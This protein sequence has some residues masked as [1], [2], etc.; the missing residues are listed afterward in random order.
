M[1]TLA[2]GKFTASAYLEW[3][4]VRASRASLFSGI[5]PA[6]IF[7]SQNKASAPDFCLNFTPFSSRIAS[8]LKKAQVRGGGGSDALLGKGEEEEEGLREDWRNFYRLPFF[9]TNLFYSLWSTLLVCLTNQRWI[10]SFSFVS[11]IFLPSLL[12]LGSLN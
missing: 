9:K 6:Q 4:R 3:A 8:R 11:E 5:S 10:V 1:H 2:A 12:K 7:S